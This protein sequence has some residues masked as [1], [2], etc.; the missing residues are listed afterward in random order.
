MHSMDLELS[1]LLGTF[2]GLALD[3]A[4]D[5]FELVCWGLA[6]VLCFSAQNLAS[7]GFSAADLQCRPFGCQFWGYLI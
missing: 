4:N 3:A 6:V 2:G 1:G 5:S 7:V